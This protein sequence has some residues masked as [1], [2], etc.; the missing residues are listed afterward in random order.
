MVTLRFILPPLVKS[1]KGSSPR[2]RK[3]DENGK[4]SSELPKKVKFDEGSPEVGKLSSTVD[5]NSNDVVSTP[6]DD[7][8]ADTKIRRK[9]K[10][11]KTKKSAEEKLE[12]DS[13]HLKVLTKKAWRQLRN[14]YLNLQRQNMSK[15]KK[16]LRD[17]YLREQHYKNC[18]QQESEDPG[19]AKSHVIEIVLD[20]PAE[21]V[22]AF[23]KQ[24]KVDLAGESEE[25]AAISGFIKYVDYEEG[26]LQ[27]YVRFGEDDCFTDRIVNFVEN[28]EKV[29]RSARILTGKVFFN[30]P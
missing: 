10:R 8:E 15:L 12:G 11:N 3:H 30:S 24:I 27:A 9:R 2:K 29:F 14:R 22:D 1:Q 25:E 16:Q 28:A 4:E 17:Q 18:M 13:I 20:S 19:M 26:Y 23:K 5:S 21:S 6:G 7:P